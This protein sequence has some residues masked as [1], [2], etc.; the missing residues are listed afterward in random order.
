VTDATEIHFEGWTLR[1]R[2]GELLRDGHTQRLSQQPLRVLIELLDHP[3]EVVTRERLVQVLWPKGVVDFDNSLNGVVRKLRVAL[4]DDSDMPRYVETLPR[5]GYRF[6]GTV[7]P[8]V[9]APPEDPGRRSCC[10]GG[11]R[12]GLVASAASFAVIVGVE[13]FALERRRSRHQS[14]RV[15]ALPQR[16]IQSLPTRRERQPAGDR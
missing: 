10:P 6:I 1:P 7:A 9:F 5:I 12:A 3:G 13:C 11:S 8:R 14:A 2:S 16:K 15:R 4:K